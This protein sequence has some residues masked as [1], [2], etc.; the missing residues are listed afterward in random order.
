MVG[1]RE[2]NAGSVGVLENDDEL[3]D[4]FMFHGR[5]SNQI[6]VLWFSVEGIRGD[7]SETLSALLDR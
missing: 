5:R 2:R 1:V 6:K 4:V 7:Q 3:S